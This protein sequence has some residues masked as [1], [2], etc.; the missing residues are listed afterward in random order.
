MIA[1]SSGAL[2]K[3]GARDYA[4]DLDPLAKE[5]ILEFVD[6]TVLDGPTEVEAARYTVDDSAV[7]PQ[8][9]P[10]APCGGRFS[11]AGLA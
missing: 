9:S 2:S 10:A 4:H 3:D 1:Q 6:L 5:R 7:W 11:I 8:K